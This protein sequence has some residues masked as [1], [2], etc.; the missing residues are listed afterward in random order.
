MGLALEAN[1]LVWGFD[2]SSEPFLNLE[3]LS[4]PA[5]SS[6]AVTGPSGSGKSSLVFLLSGMEIPRSGT[7]TWGETNLTGMGESD[8]DAWRLKNAGL[9]F[10]DFRLV[11]MLSVLEN[12]LLPIS[13]VRWAPQKEEVRRARSLLERLGLPDPRQRVASLSRGEMQRAAI[14]RA[15]LFRPSV[16][17]AD[18]PTASL[19]EASE[20]RVTDLLMEMV[21]EQGLT[22]VLTT[23]QRRLMD[24]ADQ[25]LELRHGHRAQRSGL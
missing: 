7:V 16:L 25:V 10:Q 22:L 17:F 18:E 14:A 23:H 11:P 19:D 5:G 8:R 1:D 13:F 9:L 12:V 3:R 24:R 20:A 6:L 4:V 21:R 15:L 2:R